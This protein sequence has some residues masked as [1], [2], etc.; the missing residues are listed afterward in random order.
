MNTPELG[1]LAA[2]VDGLKDQVEGVA[3]RQD[4]LEVRLEASR[5]SNQG[6]RRE[7]SDHRVEDAR[8]FAELRSDIK[9][10]AASERAARWMLGILIAIG[11]AN[12]L[13]LVSRVSLHP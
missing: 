10:L 8:S 7:L 3:S 4:Q 13:A 9:A 12:G 5:E 11:L 6:V 1:A 2:H